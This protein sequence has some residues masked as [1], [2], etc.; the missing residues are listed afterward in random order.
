[1]GA[2]SDGLSN[3]IAMSEIVTQASS[4]P[5]DVRS[6]VIRAMGYN[7]NPGGTAGG[8]KYISADQRMKCL[9][10]RNGNEL[11]PD[12]LT[13]GQDVTMQVSRSNA[14]SS[15][16]LACAFSTVNPPN[17]PACYNGSA[18]NGA[19][20]GVYPPSSYH[21]GGVNVLRWDGSVWFVTDTIDCGPATAE[22]PTAQFQSSPSVY[23]V[24]GAMGTPNGGESA[25][26]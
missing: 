25:S 26:L 6:G 2:L 19:M 21:T 18:D 7:S 12:A 1:M 16:D 11:I 3:T 4:R 5:T 17:S 9:Y 20:P 14:F 15:L 10:A 8:N 24:W 22:I 13:A 23:G